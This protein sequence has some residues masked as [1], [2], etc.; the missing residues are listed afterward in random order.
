M[1]LSRHHTTRGLLA[2]LTGVVAALTCAG[3]ASAEGIDMLTRSDAAARSA[4]VSDVAY[5]LTVTFAAKAKGFRGQAVV[6][7]A[8]ANATSPLRLDLRSTSIDALTV[9]GQAV[10]RPDSDGNRVMLP[11]AGLATGRNTIEVAYR[12]DYDRSGSGVCD[13]LDPADGREYVYTDFEPFN[14]H[15]LLPC[16]DQPDLK[17]I[18]R[19]TV[20]CP[21]GWAALGNAP[22][23]SNEGRAGVSVHRFAPT[24]LLSTYLF[25]VGAGEY[26]VFSDPRARVPSRLF[27]RRSMARYIDVQELFA[28]TRHG[29][30]FYEHYFGRPY[31]FGKYDQ[32]FAPEFNTGAMENAGAVTLNERYIYRHKA[33]DQERLERAEVMLH[34]MA[35]MWFGDLVT[36]QWWDGLWLNESFATYVGNLAL[37]R[38]GGFKAAF[39]NFLTVEK[40]GACWLDQRP[41]TH[42]VAGEV[43]D[44]NTAFSNFDDI[45]YG[46]GASL[47]KQLA[48]LVG[49]ETFR[50]GVQR[51]FARHAW[52]N[53]GTADFFTALGEAAGRP[54][55]EWCK[56]HLESRGVNTVVPHVDCEGGKVRSLRLEQLPGGG[57]AVVRPQRLQVALYAADAAGR[58]KLERVLPVMMEGAWTAVPGAVGAPAPAFVWANHG[59]HA[60]GRIFLDPVSLACV[61]GQ[62]NTIPDGLTRRGIWLTLWEMVDSAE[63]APAEFLRIVLGQAPLE[64]DAKVVEALVEAV[65]RV[66]DFYLVAGRTELTARTCQQAWKSLR[67]AAPGSDLQK[68][69]FDLVLVAASQEGELAQLE[70]LL[71]SKLTVPGLELD[72][73]TRWDL[74]ERLARFAR[75]GVLARIQAELRRDP[76]DLGKRQALAA[77]ASLP[78]LARKE[79]LWKRFVEDRDASLDLLRP[80]MHAFHQPGQE[81]LSSKFAARYFES[82]P[83]L[84]KER[85]QE[86]AADLADNLFPDNLV[87]QELVDRTRAFL[88]QNPG[89]PSDTRNPILNQLDTLERTLKIR[90]RWR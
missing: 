80:A 20:V 1:S 39:E 2:L 30:D 73:E 9:N 53:A 47:L 26:E 49:P 59:D 52:G 45:T 35:H 44:T 6:R 34:E 15:R 66:L 32:L 4:R 62:L 72:P 70:A 40:G 68:V 67:A 3:P 64:R 85:D 23:A 24:T 7:F 41:T 29:L 43:A 42:P 56:V 71:D 27:V 60:Y 14:A 54:L 79:A 69:W 83:S 84:R 81:P 33:T 25:F 21:R 13:Q 87:S 78:D 90:A 65:A 51:Y 46:K 8:L 76:T 12:S 11:A 38:G 63:L 55:T 18:L 74:V 37:E 86:F 57:S 77:E 16:F 22:E 88:A 31:P 36:M 89:L 61:A 19:L 75:P 82:I 48:F 58:L 5:D 10:A 50:R 28:L 17:G